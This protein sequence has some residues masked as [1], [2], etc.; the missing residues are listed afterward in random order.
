MISPDFIYDGFNVDN[1]DGNSEYFPVG[2]IKGVS[3][4]LFDITNWIEL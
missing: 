1:Y 3:L 4:G 2:L